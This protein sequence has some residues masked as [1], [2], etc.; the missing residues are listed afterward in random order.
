MCS[1]AEGTTVTVTVTSDSTTNYTSASATF[2]INKVVWYDCL[3]DECDLKTT[4]GGICSTCRSTLCDECEG[5]VCKTHCKGHGSTTIGG[6]NTTTTYPCDCD[7]CDESVSTSGARCSTCSD[8][9]WCSDCDDTCEYHCDG[10]DDEST[11]C[12]TCGGDG[13]IHTS[14]CSGS[15]VFDE[16]VTFSDLGG[17]AAT[18]GGCR[19]TFYTLG[20]SH[21]YDRYKCDGTKCNSTKFICSGGTWDTNVHSADCPDCDT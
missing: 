19:N 14:N 1:L 8:Y 6:G 13:I 11:E 10:H 4:S 7:D 5:K 12:S 21:T 15:Y 17:Y 16:T 20:M 9:D 3:C 18:C 2:T